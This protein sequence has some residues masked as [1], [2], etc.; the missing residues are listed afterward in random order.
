[1]DKPPRQKYDDAPV[2]KAV[3]R[4]PYA[5]PQLISYGTVAKLTATGTRSGTD[6]MAMMS[7]L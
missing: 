2:K 4:K 6:G 7:C 3:A 1:M 5:A